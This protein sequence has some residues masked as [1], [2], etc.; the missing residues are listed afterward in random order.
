[1]MES[2][3]IHGLP[4]DIVTEY[5]VPNVMEPIMVVMPNLSQYIDVFL[6]DFMALLCIYKYM[7]INKVWHLHFGMG[8]LHNTFQLALAELGI[9]SYHNSLTGRNDIA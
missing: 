5:I 4:E 6:R 9:N 3:L 1:M 7:R 2:A 8:G